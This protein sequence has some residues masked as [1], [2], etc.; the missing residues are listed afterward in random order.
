MSIDDLL[1]TALDLKKTIALEEAAKADAEMRRRAEA[2]AEKKALLDQ[3]TNP[4]GGSDQEFAPRGP[5]RRR[6]H[7]ARGQERPDRGAGAS[8]PQP[9]M[10]R[11][12]PLHQPDGA[13]LGN[14]AHR[15][16]EGN[17][18]NLVQIFSP[19]RL[20]AARADHR[21]PGRHARRHR[22]DP[23]L[24]MTMRRER[25]PGRRPGAKNDAADATK[26]ADAKG[27]DR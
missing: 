14:D 13:R 12:R 8:L 19:A 5:A 24:G 1:P 4:C 22:H 15:G 2:E 10:H 3:V 23:V 25:S 16:A 9:A 26:P 6:H 18:P 27:D 11:S 21:V 17:L 7:P 20:P